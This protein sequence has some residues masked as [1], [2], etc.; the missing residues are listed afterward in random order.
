L[1]RGSDEAV[2]LPNMGAV[3]PSREKAIE[4]FEPETDGERGAGLVFRLESCEL[5][6]VERRLIHEAR[7]VGTCLAV[8]ASSGMSKLFTLPGN[9]RCSAASLVIL[10]ASRRGRPS[11][12][13]RGANGTRE[14]GATGIGAL[15]GG[16]VE[17]IAVVCTMVGIGWKSGSRA[18]V[19]FF[20]L[21]CE[22]P[23]ERPTPDAPTTV[24]VAQSCITR[25]RQSWRLVRLEVRYIEVRQARC[26]RSRKERQ[27]RRRDIS[28]QSKGRLHSVQTV[29]ASTDSEIEKRWVITVGTVFILVNDQ[30][31]GER[32]LVEALVTTCRA[33]WHVRV[34]E[35]HGSRAARGET[36]GGME[37]LNQTLALGKRTAPP[38]E[39]QEG[40]THTST[41]TGWSRGVELDE[42]RT[43]D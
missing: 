2:R 14:E 35:N 4:P 9:C 33:L 37:G 41:A 13:S 7:R 28:K 23:N 18:G 8:S 40:G 36:A 34:P 21:V 6:M 5:E 10:L 32:S 1:F 11:W 19:A 12:L 20:L 30:A 24:A 27:Q 39:E 16:A 31:A 38:D 17:V 29:N 26:S 43:E 22:A 3:E 25:V 42:E 15:K